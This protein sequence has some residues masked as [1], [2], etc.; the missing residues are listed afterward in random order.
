MSKEKV[1]SKNE[2]KVKDEFATIN[3]SEDDFL[4]YEDIRQS[5]LY[6]MFDPRAREMSELSRSTWVAII[7]HYDTL[8][9]MYIGD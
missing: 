6:N 3:V 1:T 7:T 9:K 8:H 5:G 2:L 4:E